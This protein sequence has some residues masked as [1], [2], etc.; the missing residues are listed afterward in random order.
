[1]IT[2]KYLIITQFGHAF[3]N[4]YEILLSVLI[5]L[6]SDTSFNDDFWSCDPSVSVSLR[7][8][9]SGPSSVPPMTVLE[10]FQKVVQEYGTHLALAV[11]RAGMWKKWTYAE[12]YDTCVT[13]AKAFIKVKEIYQ[14][15]L[16]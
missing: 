9:K 14:H 13:V 10:L 8:E 6:Y 3:A 5:A 15:I 2:D 4:Q 16:I 7:V 11:K 12:Y 1:M